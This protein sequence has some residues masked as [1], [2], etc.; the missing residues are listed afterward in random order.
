MSS[1]LIQRMF[2][3][4]DWVNCG[5]F[6]LAEPIAPFR[7]I[8]LAGEFGTCSAGSSVPSSTATPTLTGEMPLILRMDS[9]AARLKLESLCFVAC[10]SAGI[11]DFAGGPILA[12]KSA[13]AIEVP[14]EG[15]DNAL[16]RCGSAFSTWPS[17][18]S[19]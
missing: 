7:R 16:A 12:M 10:L 15:Y 3:R 13:A 17:L 4:F 19:A 1:Q 5:T 14:L 11:V 18:Q 9:L 6:A 2:G 8:S